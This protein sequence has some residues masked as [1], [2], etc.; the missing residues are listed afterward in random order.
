MP[1]APSDS[2]Y[3]R[4]TRA[5]SILVLEVVVE[6][7][8]VEGRTV[9]VEEECDAEVE[10]DNEVR[11]VELVVELGYVLVLAS[12][13]V[14]CEMNGRGVSGGGD[15]GRNTV[16]GDDLDFSGKEMGIEVYDVGLADG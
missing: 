1:N 14:V 9:A 8:A 12:R 13:L 5:A 4:D 15:L 10:A 16:G 3:A 7:S 6:V 11:A 2:E